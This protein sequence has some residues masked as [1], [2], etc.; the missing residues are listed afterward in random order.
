[1]QIEYLAVTVPRHPIEKISLSSSNYYKASRH[2][3]VSGQQKNNDAYERLSAHKIDNLHSM[4]WL[5][6]RKLLFFGFLLLA[7]RLCKLL[8]TWLLDIS[9]YVNK[10]YP[11]DVFDSNWII[12]WYIAKYLAIG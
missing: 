2:A 12:V 5:E 10:F 8:R 7:K 3:I 9:L 6:A 1:M 11:T 4:K